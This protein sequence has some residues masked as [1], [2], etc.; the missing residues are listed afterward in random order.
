MPSVAIY[1]SS[2]GYGY[3]PRVSSYISE[4]EL[5][6]ARPGGETLPVPANDALLLLLLPSSSAAFAFSAA[7]AA[8]HAASRAVA[9]IFSSEPFPRSRPYFLDVVVDKISSTDAGCARNKYG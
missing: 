5:L 1:T 2:A 7:V 4:S 8:S 3:V 9:I 6:R